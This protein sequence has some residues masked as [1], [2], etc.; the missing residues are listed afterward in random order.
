MLR[1]KK[2]SL[3]DD[4]FKE[5]SIFNLSTDYKRK[6]INNNKLNAYLFV[7]ILSVAESESTDKELDIKVI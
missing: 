6:I 5:S 1:Q 2:S 3:E 7:S 4:S